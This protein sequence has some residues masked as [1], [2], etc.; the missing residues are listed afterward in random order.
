MT[1]GNVRQRE[2]S[3]PFGPTN[4]DKCGRRFFSPKCQPR[5]GGWLMC[6][7]GEIRGGC[8]P[9]RCSSAGPGGCAPCCVFARLRTVSTL[10]FTLHIL[11]P[12]AARQAHPCRMH[13]CQ[14]CRG[15][16]ALPPPPPPPAFLDLR[17]FEC[18]SW[19]SL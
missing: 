6:A 18:R 19:K 9:Q 13:C 15:L 4:E 12:P 17:N 3:K 11:S 16:S 7:Q 10:E 5:E 1:E 2:Q 14:L 8:N